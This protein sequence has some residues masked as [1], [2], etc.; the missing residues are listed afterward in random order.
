[1]SD[2][3]LMK[4][5][6]ALGEAAIQA[7]ALCFFGYPITPQ[8]EVPEYLSKRLPEVGG[9][10]V[11][12]ESE[13]ASVNMLYGAAGAGARVFTST[14]SPGLSLMTEGISYMAGS[15][16]PAVIIN[17][18]RAGPGLGGILPG[19]GDYLQAT[20]GGGHGDY[21]MVVLAPS[22]VQEA[23]DL[24]MDAFDIADRYRNP[25]M[26]MGDGLI[27]QM[28]EPV[29]F[30]PRGASDL[31]VKSWAT[32]G[33]KGRAPNIVNSLF[34][35][36]L[37]LEQ[38]NIMLRRKY[39][40]ITSQESRFEH[41]GAEGDLDLLIVAYG[42]VARISKTTADELNREGRKVAVFRPI[43]LWPFA[44][45]ELRAR[46][47]KARAILVV[48]L[49]MGQMIEDVRLST[50]DR[51]PISFFGRAGGM[52]CSPEE[53]LHVARQVLDGK[54]VTVLGD[55]FSSTV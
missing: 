53:V 27:G 50:S 19:Q 48:E 2:K 44:E 16:L 25:V 42:T 12:A 28:M 51:Q 4:G 6:E 21:R 55:P 14:S 33:A 34:L 5:C 17:I 41:Y 26:V 9:V 1:M 22:T 49:S 7:G 30:N 45:A 3:K 36:P 39:E 20:K 38:H 29:Q 46:A 11:Q 47:E 13:V 35:D 18:V 24:M 15:E 52:V 31:P 40:R 32:T 8:T 23:A 10:F 54:K 43:T 37:E